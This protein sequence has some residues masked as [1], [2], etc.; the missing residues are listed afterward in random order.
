MA[1]AMVISWTMTISLVTWKDPLAQGWGREENGVR[2]RTCSTLL[3]L[4]KK[5]IKFFS[6]VI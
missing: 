2:T 5:K 6:T 3:A 1:A 4:I